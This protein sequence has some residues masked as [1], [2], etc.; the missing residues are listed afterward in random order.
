MDRHVGNVGRSLSALLVLA[1][2]TVGTSVAQ[3]KPKATFPLKESANGHY[4]VGHNNVP[5]F[6]A[7]DASWT[8]ITNLTKAD[9]RR[10]LDDR[11]RHGS[12]AVFAYLIENTYSRKAPNNIYGVAPFNTPGDFSTPNPVYFNHAAWVVKQ[13]E[14]RGMAVWLLPAFLGFGAGS[15]GWWNDIIANGPAKMRAYGRY[16]GRRFRNFSNI[17]WMNGGDY[18]PPSGSE[19]ERNALEILKGINDIKPAS[20]HTFHG[21]RSPLGA[22]ASTGTL[23]TDQANFAPFLNLNGVYHSDE[24]TFPSRAGEVYRLSRRA[25]NQPNVMPAYVI[26]GRYECPASHC[27]SALPSYLTNDPARIRRQAY[28]ADLSGATGQFFGNEFVWSFGNSELANGTW[29]GPEGIGSVGHQD[30]ER[31]NRFFTSHA[32]YDLVPD[33]NQTTVTAG[34]G[35]FGAADYVT[36]ARTGGGSLVMAYVPPTGTEART[37]TVNMSRLSRKTTAQ[38]FNPATGAYIAVAGSPFANAGSRDFTTPGDN[39]TGANDWVLVLKAK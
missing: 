9:A 27:P 4:L 24:D 32:W 12:T 1:L 35:T 20:F 8:I 21:A 37:L 18:S 26:E 11:A 14:K 30:M 25:Y 36:S 28:W 39:G 15:D 5:F 6:I 13:A 34:Y 31:L 29:D 38:W 33:Q 3:A 7:G 19:G 10:Y 2:L 17:V 22:A 23:S 16:L